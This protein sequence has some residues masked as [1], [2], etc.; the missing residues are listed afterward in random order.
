MIKLYGIPN[1][2]TVKKAR[3]W[4]K[5]N[6][7]EYTFEDFKK[8]EI[9]TDMLSTWIATFGLDKLINKRGTTWRKLSADE[10]SACTEI[11]TAIPI[12]ITH[13]SM[14]K[15][16]I[17]THNDQGILIGFSIESWGKY[18]QKS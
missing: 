17:V 8:I 9:T 5:G 6:A 7:I 15:R 4:L 12:I 3:A 10:Q 2:D 13:L 1:C 16:P 18:F 11:D 14:I